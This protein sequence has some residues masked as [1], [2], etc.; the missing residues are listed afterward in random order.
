MWTFLSIVFCLIFWPNR[1]KCPVFV[2][3]ALHEQI[4][5]SRQ[6]KTTNEICF[7]YNHP[8]IIIYM[9][10]RVK[11]TRSKVSYKC[12]RVKTLNKN[13]LQKLN[14]SFS[15]TI[16]NTNFIYKNIRQLNVYY[17]GRIQDFKLG[18]ADL[19]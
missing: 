6:M 19:K 17:Q 1:L 18:G 5:M 2:C 11:G 16:F 4:N 13:T 10:F 7:K 8:P 14:K 15:N 9:N 12:L 3:L